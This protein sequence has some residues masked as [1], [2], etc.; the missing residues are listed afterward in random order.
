[1]VCITYITISHTRIPMFHTCKK[2]KRNT[3]VDFLVNYLGKY[4]NVS[5][6][7]AK[8]LSNQRIKNYE[9]FKYLKES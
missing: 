2:S 9:T 5:N 3:H 7:S 6:S 4:L 8:Y 1:M